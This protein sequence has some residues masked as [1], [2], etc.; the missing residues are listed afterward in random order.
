LALN[1]MFMAR[2]KES[3]QEIN[4][5]V[6]SIPDGDGCTNDLDCDMINQTGF[7]YGLV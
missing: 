2:K 5:T 3:K 1:L 7:C 6:L 4:S